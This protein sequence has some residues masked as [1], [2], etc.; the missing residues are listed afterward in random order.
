MEPT[1][2]MSLMSGNEMFGNAKLFNDAVVPFSHVARPSMKTVRPEE[3]VLMA[4]PHNT[5]SA[6]SVR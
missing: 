1:K 3:I 4:V 6:R 2:G 5:L